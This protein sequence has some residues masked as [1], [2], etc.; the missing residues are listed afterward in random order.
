MWRFRQ[1]IQDAT[2]FP[3]T[4][5]NATISNDGSIKLLGSVTDSC[6]YSSQGLRGEGRILFQTSHFLAPRLITLDYADG[7]EGLYSQF[8]ASYIGQV[9]RIRAEFADFTKWRAMPQQTFGFW[10]AQGKVHYLGPRG[11]IVWT[12]P[13]S[14][15]DQAKPYRVTVFFDWLNGEPAELLHCHAEFTEPER[16]VYSADM[17][18]EDFNNVLQN[19]VYVEIV[20]V[21]LNPEAPEGMAANYTFN[22]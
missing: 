7:S 21:S 15:V 8:Q 4:Q 1:D 22:G 20:Q 18:R 14:I 12:D 17:Q 3:C 19:T 2:G 16:F 10:I 11:D 5:A 9:P 6:I 13:I